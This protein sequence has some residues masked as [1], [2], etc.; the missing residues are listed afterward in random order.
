MDNEKF[1]LSK[2]SKNI[3]AKS[4]TQP[5]PPTGQKRKRIKDR[6]IRWKEHYHERSLPL[7]KRFNKDIGPGSYYRWEGHDYTTDSDYFVV[8]GPAVQKHGQKSFF[9]GIKKYPPKWERKKVY[10]PSGKYFNNIM[11][12]LSHTSKMW[13][14]TMPQNQQEY[15]TVDLANVKIPR[16]VKA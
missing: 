2:H 4:Y 14:V 12:A 3:E 13:G 6:G 7:K 16:H 5:K 8:V 11:S 10:A 9:A 15:N 1:N